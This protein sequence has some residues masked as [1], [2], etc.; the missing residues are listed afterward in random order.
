M[1]YKLKCVSCGHVENRE[2]S[3]RCSMCGGVLELAYIVEEEVLLEMDGEPGI[4][5]YRNLFPIKAKTSAITLKEGN[6]P[7]VDLPKLERK[8][9]IKNIAVKCEHLNPTG[10]FKDRGMAA[11]VTKAMELD[12][13]KVLV[14][15]A[16]NASASAAAYGARAGLPVTAIVPEGTSDVK[17][18]QA[19]AYGA[20]VIREPGN[21][22]DAY[23]RAMEM[24]K[25]QEWYNVTTTYINPYLTAGYK[26]ISYELF[27]QMEKLPDWIAVP[28]GAGPLLGAVY[29]GFRDLL[30]M[31]RIAEIPRLIGVQSDRC[32][33]IAEAYEQNHSVRAYQMTK[34]TIASGLNDELRG[35]EQDGE[36][37]LA[38]IY[39][40][41]GTAVAVEENAIIASI[42][43]LAQEGIY[44][45]PASA[46]SVAAI[47]KLMEMEIIQ[48]QDSV[49]MIATGNG[50]KSGLK[51]EL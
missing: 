26:S 5:K 32:C 8:L 51:E 27:E 19:R 43:S 37:T 13:K 12:C 3:Y 39:A 16:G 18:T 50:L 10:S 29:Q 42:S 9:G 36:R 38:Y 47:E 21:Y 30:E 23:Q 1:E 2:P 33:P 22:S 48:P 28:I 31:G 46:A 24:S 6:T 35:Y 15:S 14:A 49:V 25:D 44:V 34:K 40:S 20:R 45:E 17:M 4:F 41:R 11:A 7:L